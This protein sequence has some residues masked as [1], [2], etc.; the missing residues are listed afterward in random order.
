[1]NFS[2]CTFNLGSNEMITF[3]YADTLTPPS[4]LVIKMLKINFIL[5]MTRSNIKL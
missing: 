2:V 3:S 1:M 4:M 5:N